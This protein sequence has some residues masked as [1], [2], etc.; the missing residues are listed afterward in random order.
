[1]KKHRY[2]AFAVFA[3][4]LLLSMI[5]EWSAPAACPLPRVD[6][7]LSLAIGNLR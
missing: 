6:Q 7:A 5:R 2:L 4:A 3:T 1:M